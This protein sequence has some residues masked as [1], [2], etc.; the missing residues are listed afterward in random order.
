MKKIAILTS[1]GDSP[2]MN[3]VVHYVVKQAESKGWETYAIFEGYKGM[4]EDNIKKISSKDTEPYKQKGGTAIYSARYPEFKNEEIREKAVK[5]L[6]SKGIETLVVIG[7]DGSLTG[8]NLLE[9]YGIQII[10]APGTID[11]DVANTS[12]TIGFPTAVNTVVTAIEQI[13]DTSRSHDRAAIVEIMGRHSG[14]IAATAGIEANVDV[15]SV[16]E[17]KLTEEEI[18]E[19]VKSKKE[20]QREVI[21]AVT[22]LMYDVHSLAKKIQEQTGIETRATVLGHT[23][24]GGQPTELEV[25]NAKL[26]ATGIIDSIEKEEKG[27]MITI[28]ENNNS[29]SSIKISEGIKSR[30]E[31][32]VLEKIRKIEEK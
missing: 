14:E 19:R 20:G 11:N 12:S 29:H 21:V 2:G 4:F 13:R 9:K 27:V 28:D 17:K 22:E 15:I 23:Q 31:K 8:A 10:G 18:V 6:E 1:G 5:N 3:T 16:P 24:R 7:G 25:S 30:D 32:D 26:Y